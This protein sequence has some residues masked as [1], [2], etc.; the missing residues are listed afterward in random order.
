MS[1]G[2]RPLFTQRNFTA[3]WIGQLISILGERLTYLGLLGLLAAHTDQFRAPRS[4]ELLSLLANVML[5]PVL[6]FAPFTGAWLDRSNLKRVLIVSD[7]LRGLVVALIPLLYATTQHSGPV[8]AMV[9]ALFTCNVLFLPAKSAITPEIVSHDQLLGANALLSAAGIAATA[10]G[11]LAGGWVVDHWGWPAALWINA[12][13]Y[14]VSVVSLA[15]I[16]YHPQETRAHRPAVSLRGYWSE[17]TQGWSRVKASAAVGLGMMVLAAVWVGGGFLHVAGNQHVQQSASQPGMERVGVL[18]CALGLGAGLGTW[19]VNH[20]GRSWPRS[21]ILG[22]GLLLGCLALIAVA[23]SR[24]FAVF[25]GAAFFLGLS[26]APVFMLSET[27][28]QI[29]T[30]HMERG[31]VFSARDFI[32][33]LVFL[34]GVTAAGAV[35]KAGGTRAALL[36]CA[37]LMALAGFGALAWRRADEELSGTGAPVEPAAQS[38]G[39]S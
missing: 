5:A 14:L 23:V 33:R 4:S 26:V 20:H 17:V 25:A 13:T 15:L 38:P 1:A 11:A 39:G 18:L 21:R 10:V 2:P 22:I 36:M 30:A 6:L 35:T 28:I 19:W 29:G 37:G 7:T 16:K 9:F 34:I 8:F 32:M 3:L 31:R 24:R 12:V 27:L